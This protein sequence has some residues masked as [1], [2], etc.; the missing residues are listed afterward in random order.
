MGRRRRGLSPEESALWEKVAATAT[1]MH[2]SDAVMA[3]GPFAASLPLPD[4]APPPPAKTPRR[5][6]PSAPAVSIHLAPDPHEALRTANP[7]MDR[8]RFEKLRRGRME[9]EAR[10]DLHGMTSEEAHR[11]LVSFI[12]T[13]EAFDHRLVLIITGKGR[14][15]EDGP[16]P[17]R[18]GILRHSL[19]HWLNTPP[20]AGRILQVAEA[21]AR[22]GG[23]G[24]FYVCL[25]RRR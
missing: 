23:G 22:H 15:T 2:G 6:P 25:R 13:A 9:P 19:P 10:L 7:H 4:M 16:G 14:A 3:D 11:R 18:H 1:P 20:L 8:R 24:A 21:H 17:R 5:P 12:L